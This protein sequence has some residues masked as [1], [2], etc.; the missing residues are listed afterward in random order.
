[1]EKN[2]IF[3]NLKRLSDSKN[4]LNSWMKNLKKLEHLKVKKENET[5]GKKVIVKRTKEDSIYDTVV[6]KEKLMLAEEQ[7]K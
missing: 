7:K 6:L 1:M 2:E 5:V 3:V 4:S